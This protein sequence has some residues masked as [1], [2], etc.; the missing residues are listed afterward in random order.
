MHLVLFL[1]LC[2]APC[3]TLVCADARSVG[4][5]LLRQD[6]CTVTS[7]WTDV[8]FFF[9]VIIIIIFFFFFFFFFFFCSFFF[10]SQAR[11]LRVTVFDEIFVGF[12]HYAGNR[13]PTVV[14]ALVEDGFGKMQVNGPVRQKDRGNKEQR[15]AEKQRD[16]WVGKRN[17]ELNLRDSKAELIQQAW[18]P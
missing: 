6:K 16:T 5:R 2:E 17:L 3:C 10:P 8:R 9:F 15:N 14:M 11:T 18:V 12:S 7:V 1:F 4:P 13:I